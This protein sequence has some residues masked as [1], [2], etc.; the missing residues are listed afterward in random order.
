MAL[1]LYC[2]VL[3]AGDEVRDYLAHFLSDHTITVVLE[4]RHGVTT[5]VR[6]P[7]VGAIERHT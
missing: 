6:N 2:A 1:I 5:P 3:V 7:D 4:L